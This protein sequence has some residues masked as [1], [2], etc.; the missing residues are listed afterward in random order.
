ML[1]DPYEP[2]TDL[3]KANDEF[4][5]D[6]DF[7]AVIKKSEINK[8]RYIILKYEVISRYS[9]EDTFSDGSPTNFELFL[10]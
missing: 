7:V 1:R 5:A 2:S 6:A 10:D 9:T 3:D 8:T 4:S